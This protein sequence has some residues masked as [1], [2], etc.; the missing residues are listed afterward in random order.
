M[1]AALPRAV[2]KGPSGPPAPGPLLGPKRGRSR[3]SAHSQRNTT[4]GRVGSES[5]L[6]SRASPALGA[7]FALG[8]TARVAYA[9]GGYPS[10][11]RGQTVNLLAQPSQVRI[12]LRP[13]ALFQ[14]GSESARRSSGSHPS[15]QA[16]LSWVLHCVCRRGERRGI[17]PARARL[18]IARSATA[19]WAA[20][21][22]SLRTFATLGRVD[23]RI[24][25]NCQPRA[26]SPEPT[27]PR[28]GAGG[29]HI[30]RFPRAASRA[31]SKRCR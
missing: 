19:D 30:H 15:G 16:R 11:Q 2:A 25:R 22:S 23:G 13:P 3:R 17:T 26:A 10:G 29:A 4:S 21:R 7:R 18:R 9:A 6:P 5:S 28:V 27:A 20:L 14:F 1:L 8:P 31:S 24:S 12:L